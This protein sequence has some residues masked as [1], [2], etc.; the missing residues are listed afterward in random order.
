M[1]L[2]FLPKALDAYKHVKEGFPERAD[3]IKVLLSDILEHP[4]RGYG[5]PMQLQGKYAGV[6]VRKIS[7]EDSIYYVF[8]AEKVVVLSISLQSNP[9]MDSG[10]ASSTA[11]HLNV[12]SFSEDEYASVLALMEANRGRDAEPKVQLNMPFT[13]I[14]ECPGDR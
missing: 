4:E 5:S 3:K 7:F 11:D 1:N 8:N 10:N 14:L 2:E 9:V 6:W 13:G 12:E